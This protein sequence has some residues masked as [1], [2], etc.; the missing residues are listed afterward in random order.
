MMDREY[1]LDCGAE[2]EWEETGCPEEKSG[3]AVYYLELRPCKECA[4]RRREEVLRSI[5]G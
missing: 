2:L 5:G 1:C 4:R 3:C